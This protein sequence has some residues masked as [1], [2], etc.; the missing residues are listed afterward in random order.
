[1]CVCRN[2]CKE[3]SP[4]NAHFG[5]TLRKRMGFQYHRFTTH[6]KKRYHGTITYKARSDNLAPNIHLLK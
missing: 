1:M 4:G 6:W 5:D 2:I 3:A